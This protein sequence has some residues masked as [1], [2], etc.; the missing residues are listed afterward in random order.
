MNVLLIGAYERDNF[1]DALFY[2]LTSKVLLSYGISVVASSLIYTR[3]TQIQDLTIFP[4]DN[5][6]NE[7]E[8]DAVWVVGGE[9]GG[10]DVSAALSMSLTEEEYG[11]YSK[12]NLSMR[13]AARSFLGAPDSDKYLAYV[14]DLSRYS[15]NKRAELVI[16]SA[17]LSAP[18]GFSNESLEEHSLG[19]YRQAHTLSVRDESSLQLLKDTGRN[20]ARISPDLV[21][22]LPLVYPDLIKREGAGSSIIFQINEVLCDR[23]GVEMIVKELGKIAK[24]T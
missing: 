1:G 20:D 17:G 23:F 5:L 7:Y 11:K 22:A 3:N 4:Y 21:H 2:Y 24:K 15:R 16:N 12:L 6:L 14:P 13:R 8:W 10:P 9:V 19:I 18:G